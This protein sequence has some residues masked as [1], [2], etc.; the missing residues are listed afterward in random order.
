MMHFARDLRVIKPAGRNFE[1]IGRVLSLQHST[2]ALGEKLGVQSPFE[3]GKRLVA[4]KNVI[5]QL[6]RKIGE[7]LAA[8]GPLS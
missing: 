5:L 3:Q 7:F 1:M 4:F 6:L 2:I 8:G